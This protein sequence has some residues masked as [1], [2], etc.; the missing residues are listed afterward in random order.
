MAKLIKNIFISFLF[1]NSTF[2]DSRSTLFR[3]RKIRTKFLDLNLDF[4]RK[5]NKVIRDSDCA[6][7]QQGKV[8]AD[9][10]RHANFSP[11]KYTV[12]TKIGNQVKTTE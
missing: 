7:K 12:L 3:G 5:S 9:K 1:Y 6:N 4:H 8:Y 11:K 2:C 10:R